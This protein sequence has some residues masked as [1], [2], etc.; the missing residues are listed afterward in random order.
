MLSATPKLNSI[1]IRPFAQNNNHIISNTLDVLK[2]F[3]WPARRVLASQIANYTLLRHH[4][5]IEGDALRHDCTRPVR[6]LRGLGNALDP[7]LNQ[8]GIE[9][10]VTKG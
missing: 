9:V 10:V 8:I 1:K 5:L 4:R 3:D 2:R 6:V 7:R